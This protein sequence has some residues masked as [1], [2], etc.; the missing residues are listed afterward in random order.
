MNRNRSDLP[1]II[2]PPPLLF[3]ACLIAGCVADRVFP[4]RVFNWDWTARLLF[5]CLF[6]VVSVLIA[7]ISFRV[8]KNHGTPVDPARSTVTIVQDGPFRVSRNPLYLALLL[9]FLGLTVLMAS[10]W[11]LVL[12]PVLFVLL[13]FGVVK[14][15]EGYLEKKFGEEYRQ[16]KARVRRWI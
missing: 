11:L 10:F 9:S 2:A 13:H 8:L 12:L 14:P 7:V 3:F 4:I 6:F 15:E 1:P 5:G 16:Y